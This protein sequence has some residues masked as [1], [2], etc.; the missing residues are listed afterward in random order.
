MEGSHQCRN[1]G[2]KNECHLG[3]GELTKRKV[4][5]RLQ[6]VFIIKY[7]SNGIVERYKAQ[8]FAKGYIQSYGID[9]QETFALVIKMNSIQVLASLTRL[10]SSIVQ[11]E[12]CFPS[13]EL[14]RSSI[15]ESFFGFKRYFG[16]GKVCKLKKSF[17]RLK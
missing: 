3:G 16:D 7:Q 8:L 17:H 1:E 11:R 13:R 12:K 5:S 10:A 6:W 4:T 2:T 14:G 15:H 9:Y